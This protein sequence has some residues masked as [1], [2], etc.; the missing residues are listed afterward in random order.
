MARVKPEEVVDALER[1][2]KK[3]LNDTM[4]QFAPGVKYSE[5]DLFRFFKRAVDRHCNS[6]ESV[7]DGC[8]ET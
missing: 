8:V 6:W 1:E 5:S 4:A 2:F 7:P 3:A